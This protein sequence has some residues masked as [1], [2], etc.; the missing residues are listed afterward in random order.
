MHKFFIGLIKIYQWAI[1]P[2][3]GAN[4]RFIPTCSEYAVEAID[5]YG[6]LKGTY[7]ATKRISRC[8]PWC[9]GGH[10]PVP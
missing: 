9:E 8:H 10:D 5:K 1:S 3:L 4:C 2:F 7:L 6:V